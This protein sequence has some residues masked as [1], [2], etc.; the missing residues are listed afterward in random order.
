MRDEQRSV[1]RCGVAEE[2]LRDRVRALGQ[3]QPSPAKSSQV[4]PSPAKSSQVFES[5]GPKAQSAWWWWEGGGGQEML[6]GRRSVQDLPLSR[7]LRAPR[8]I[9]TPINHTHRHL[10]EQVAARAELR[11][12]VRDGAL[13]GAGEEAKL[14]AAAHVVRVLVGE[15][16]GQSLVGQ[17]TIDALGGHQLAQLD[18]CRVDNLRGGG[19]QRPVSFWGETGRWGRAKHRLG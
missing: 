2:R 13:G 19:E 16:L 7:V 11:V 14:D 1:K 5:P 6:G 10:K 3:V 17:A 4:Q 12:L 8:E 18:D 15:L 9:G